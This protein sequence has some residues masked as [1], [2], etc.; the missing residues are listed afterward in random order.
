MKDSINVYDVSGVFSKNAHWYSPTAVLDFRVSKYLFSRT[1][2]F[3]VPELQFFARQCSMTFG[4][5]FAAQIFFGSSY[6]KN[7]FVKSVQVYWPID[8]Y[9]MVHL[10][11]I[12]GTIASITINKPSK[13]G[14]CTQSRRDMRESVSGVTPNYFQLSRSTFGFSQTSKYFRM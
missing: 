1:V 2:S 11:L 8:I 14:S 6:R 13:F 7:Y 12:R 9:S 5:Q 10:L 3:N 4:I